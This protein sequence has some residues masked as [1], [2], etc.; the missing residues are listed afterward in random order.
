MTSIEEA[1]EITKI[2][3][4]ADLLRRIHRSCFTT[5]FQAH[6]HTIS[7]TGLVSDEARPQPGEISP[8]YR[9]YCSWMSRVS[10]AKG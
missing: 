6:H 7:Y 2:Y 1:L 9:E 4:V 5:P 3:S 10:L 8:A